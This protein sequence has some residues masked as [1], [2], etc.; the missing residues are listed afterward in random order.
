MNIMEFTFPS[1]I[2]VYSEPY[3]DRVNKEYVRIL[4]LDNMPEGAIKPFVKPLNQQPLSPF[5]NRSVYDDPFQCTY[6]LVKSSH[7][8]QH[9]IPF[10]MERDVPSLITFLKQNGYHIDMDLFKIV[11]KSGGL[12]YQQNAATG[13]QKKM[14][15]T[16]A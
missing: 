3:L 16:F 6:A 14:L 2:T 4:T 7:M 10:F 15:F 1:A 12:K 11:S 13:G 5:Y 8:S 9:C